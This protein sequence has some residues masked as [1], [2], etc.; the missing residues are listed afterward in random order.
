[1]FSYW[2]SLWP[3]HQ[4]SKADQRMTFAILLENF[5]ELCVE[6]ARSLR[7]HMSFEFITLIQFTESSINH[8]NNKHTNWK[9]NN[10]LTIFLDIL[11]RDF[12]K[13]CPK[14]PKS[15]LWCRWILNWTFGSIVQFIMVLNA[16][17]EGL[18]LII[19]YIAVNMFVGKE[20]AFRCTFRFS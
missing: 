4:Y 7:V 12:C 11:Y 20:E 1:M 19:F 5:H 14:R 15:I 3:F 2:S 9:C 6:N 10:N 16:L 13:G 18:G 17:L 8:E